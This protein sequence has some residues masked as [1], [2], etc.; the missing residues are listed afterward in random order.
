MD[1]E[2]ILIIDDDAD[3]AEGLAEVISLLGYSPRTA[4]SGEEGLGLANA[5]R[6]EFA[7]ID[8]GLSDINGVECA[9]ALKSLQQGMRCA[10][11]TGYAADF[12]HDVNVGSVD[13][14]VLMKPVT[15]EQIAAALKP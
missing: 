2:R 1:R 6:F 3:F 12:L 8:I 14:P 4:A 10:L 7:F 11:V 9:R 5:M 15:L 13:A